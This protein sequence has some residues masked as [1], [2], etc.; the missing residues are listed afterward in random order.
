[1]VSPVDPLG[2][3]VNEIVLAEESDDDGRGGFASHFHL[4]HHAMCRCGAATAGIDSFVESLR[5]GNP[6][7]GALEAPGVPESARGF[8]GQTFDII[9]GENRAPSLRRSRSAAKTCSLPSSIALS[10]S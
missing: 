5:E 3:L 4:Y 9:D 2:R 1:M 8:V 10:T 7:S 6:L